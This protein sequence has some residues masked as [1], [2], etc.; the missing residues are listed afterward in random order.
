MSEFV[1]SIA[2]LLTLNVVAGL[3][4]IRWGPT[5]AD[6]ILAAQLFSTTGTAVLLLLAEATS[7]PA[8]RDVALVSALLAA[9]ST[10][11]FVRLLGFSSTQASSRFD[12]H[13]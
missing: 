11:V 12:D 3:L 6:R 7:K 4:R 10:V 8:L 1:M 2:F 5:A 13:N 9:V